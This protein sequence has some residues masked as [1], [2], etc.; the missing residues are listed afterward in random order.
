[1]TPDPGPAGQR[2][3]EIAVRGAG[4]EMQPSEGG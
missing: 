4:L 1:M 3:E 2:L